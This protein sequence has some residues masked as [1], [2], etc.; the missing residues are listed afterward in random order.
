MICQNRVMLVGFMQASF[1]GNQ[2]SDRF[3]LRCGNVESISR[4]M[5]AL[6]STLSCSL[7]ESF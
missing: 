3:A 7:R 4:G 6:V 2:D 1:G 5:A